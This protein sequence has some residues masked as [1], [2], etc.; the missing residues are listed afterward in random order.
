MRLFRDSLL[1]VENETEMLRGQAVI[2]DIGIHANQSG[3]SS[4][5]P[6]NIVTF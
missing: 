6:P 3:G 2:V 1:L 5:T 4:L